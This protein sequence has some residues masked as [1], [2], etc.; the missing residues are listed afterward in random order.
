MVF[1]RLQTMSQNSWYQF[2]FEMGLVNLKKTLDKF[3]EVMED[4]V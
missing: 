1:F 3:K 2:I 4:E